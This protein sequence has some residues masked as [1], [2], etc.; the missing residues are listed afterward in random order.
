[1][2]PQIIC[3]SE[4][5]LRTAEIDKLNSYQYTIGTSFCRQLYSYGGIC[6]MVHKNI[7]FIPIN[8]NIYNTEKDLKISALKLHFMSNLFIVVCI[9]RS[10]MGDF[11]YFLNQLELILNKL[12]KMSNEIISCGNFNINYSNDNSRK[13]LL[14]SLLA[15]F[16]LFSTYKVEEDEV[17]GTCGTNEIEEER[18]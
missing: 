9:Y 16:N 12:Y 3:L 10:P 6:I 11:Y 18:V 1:M 13:D 2:S 14:N 17:G 5:H 15:S 4:H 7:Q 8:L